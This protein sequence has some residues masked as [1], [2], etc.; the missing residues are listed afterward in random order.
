M[1]WVARHFRYRRVNGCS[2]FPAVSLLAGLTV[3]AGQ[4]EAHAQGEEPFKFMN[5]HIETNAS[6]CDM[7]V[8]V[9]FDTDGVTELSIEDPNGAVV[10]RSQTP[11]GMEDTQDQTEGFQERVEPPIVELEDALGCDPS[12]DAISLD[13]LFEAWPAGKYEF[14]AMSDGVEFEGTTR[15]THRIPAGPDITGPEDGTV[16]PDDQPLVIRWE[17]VTDPI[18]PGLG[19]VKIVGY[20]VVLKDVSTETQ[21]PLLPAA[22]DVDVPSSETSV[23]VPAQYFVRNRIYEFE[24]LATDR[25]GNQTITEGGAVCTVPINPAHCELP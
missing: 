13:E 15:L 16:I 18:I 19:P 25:G 11:V 23:V 9:L 21:G 7:G 6:G 8:Q 10:F 22:F 1:Y 14:E 3:F 12:D 4:Q 17:E 20:H 5:I 24:V 2:W